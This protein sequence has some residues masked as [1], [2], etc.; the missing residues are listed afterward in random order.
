MWAVDVPEPAVALPDIAPAVG[1]A[2]AGAFAA[3]WL[4]Q[5]PSSSSAAAAA[6]VARLNMTCP[7]RDLGCYSQQQIA[8]ALS[9]APPAHRRTVMRSRIKK[10]GALARLPATGSRDEHT[11]R[12]AERGSRVTMQQRQHGQGHKH[13]TEY[14]IPED[15]RRRRATVDIH[16]MHR[17]RHAY[18]PGDG[19]RH[20]AI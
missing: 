13:Y 17:N 14:G 9:S 12:R 20:H 4:A 2:L 15:C 10:P 1:S 18:L 3:R 11:H 7:P 8:A 6:I 5:A 19:G 16:R